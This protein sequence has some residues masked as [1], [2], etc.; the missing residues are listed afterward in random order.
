[1]RPSSLSDFATPTM[2]ATRLISDIVVSYAMIA[3]DCV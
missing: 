1:M 3:Y 2:E